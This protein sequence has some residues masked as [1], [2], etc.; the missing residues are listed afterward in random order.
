MMQRTVIFRALGTVNTIFL[1]QKELGGVADQVKWRILE[2]DRKLSMFLPESEIS[3]L[4]ANAGKCPV[5]VDADTFFL[6]EQAKYWSEQSD[7]VFDV[8]AAPLSILWRSAKKNRTIPKQ[9][10]QELARKLVCFKDLQ[11][12]PSTHTAMLRCSGQAVDL[13]GIAKGF[14]A[15]EAAKIMREAGVE[16]ALLNLGGNLIALGKQPNGEPWN[17]GVQKPFAKNGDCIASLHLSDRTMVT[18]G[19]YENCFYHEG[20]CYHHLID[21]RT[22][23][24]GESELTAVT[25]VAEKSVD[26]DALSTAA[27]L[28]GAEKGA[29]LLQKHNAEGIFLCRDRKI[30]ATP[31]LRSAVRL[32]PAVVMPS[33]PD[34]FRL[35]PQKT[36]K[37]WSSI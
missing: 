19:I 23:R 15:D 37:E 4:N 31:G 3:R 36:K 34:A 13:G 20:I 26:A 9:S 22:G 2:L 28:L 6:L 25:V 21:P 35:K 30:F 8:T 7:G 14:A 29:Q 1:P 17:L 12:T 27:F 32:T 24:P 18:S 11:L 16:N 10:E 5:K 33:L